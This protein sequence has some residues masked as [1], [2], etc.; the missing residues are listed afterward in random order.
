M[1]AGHLQWQ[2]TCRVCPVCTLSW[3]TDHW[4]LLE[5]YLNP[6]FIIG[7]SLQPVTPRAGWMSQL[8]HMTAKVAAQEI[9]IVVDAKFL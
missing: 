9:D 2:E 8:C 5:R 1:A 4:C 6:I 3:N 7:W